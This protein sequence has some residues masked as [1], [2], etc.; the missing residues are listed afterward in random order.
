MWRLLRTRARPAPVPA[1]D[2]AFVAS[3]VASLEATSRIRLG[4]GLTLFLVAAGDCGGCAAELEA[5]AELRCDL[6]RLGLCFVTTPRHA[7]VLLVSG[8]LTANLREAVEL[9]HEAMPDPKWV[10]GIGDC[11]ADGGI[12]RGSYAVVGGVGQ[13]VPVDM[14]IPGCPPTPAHILAGLRALL[15]AG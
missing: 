15:A 12:F 6:E 14:V 5:L 10:V 7:D 1:P 4:R 11:A 8:A 13:A 9:A 2:P 3:L